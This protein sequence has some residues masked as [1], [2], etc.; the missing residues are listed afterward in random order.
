MQN[1]GPFSVGG[2]PLG[3]SIGIPNGADVNLTAKEARRIA[4]V[5]ESAGALTIRNMRVHAGMDAEIRI[6][7]NS[8]RLQRV[9][10]VQLARVLRME[11]G[12]S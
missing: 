1:V 4:E 12:V 5:L 10:A 9:L 2:N 6:G 11:A 3:I 8:H 7:T